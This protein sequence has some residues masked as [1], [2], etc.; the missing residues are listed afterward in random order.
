VTWTQVP[1]ALGRLSGQRGEPTIWA[2]GGRI[3]VPASA[4]ALVRRLGEMPALQGVRGSAATALR[5]LGVLGD[6]DLPLLVR[7]DAPRKL[8]GWRFA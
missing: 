4:Q 5:A 2:A 6:E 3:T 1:I 8:D 7:P